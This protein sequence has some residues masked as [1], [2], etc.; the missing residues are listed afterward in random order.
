MIFQQTFQFQKHQ[1][2]VDSEMI[3]IHQFFGY[4]AQLRWRF[5]Q[6]VLR[7]VALNEH[8]GSEQRGFGEV[9]I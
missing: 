1:E 2:L 5:Q 9:L 7:T 3:D 6:H 4:E 8:S